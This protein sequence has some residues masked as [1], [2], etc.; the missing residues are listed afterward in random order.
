MQK[1]E[2]ILF[3]QKERVELQLSLF[4]KFI[5]ESEQSLQQNDLQYLILNKA[6]LLN[7]I[8]ELSQSSF[9]AQRTD[10]IQLSCSEFSFDHSQET[11][12]FPDKKII[13]A[14]I[15]KSITDLLQ[16]KLSIPSLQ[17]LEINIHENPNTLETQM[18]RQI[19]LAKVQTEEKILNRKLKKG[20][21]NK[22]Q[23]VA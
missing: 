10:N 15:L 8:S 20:L 12:N 3:H 21:N 5:L 4:E 14:S 22:S 23:N 9:G 2:K 17:Q 1:N 7:F 19:T 11:L 6:N 16:V 13:I 18:Q